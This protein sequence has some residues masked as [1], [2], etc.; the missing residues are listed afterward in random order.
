MKAASTDAAYLKRLGEFGVQSVPAAR[1]SPDGFAAY[2]RAEVAKWA[3]VIKA[4]G[5][6][7]D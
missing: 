5:V 4:A 6:F 2:F 7:A 3:P 1:S